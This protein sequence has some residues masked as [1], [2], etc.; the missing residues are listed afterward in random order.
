MTTVWINR[1]GAVA[2]EGDATPDVEITDL[3]D[4]AAGQQK[5]EDFQA[6]LVDLRARNGRK[7]SFLDLLNR[8]GLRPD[9]ATR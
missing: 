7:L 3:R 9:R 5:A 6:L 1:T 2:G 4:L 8:A